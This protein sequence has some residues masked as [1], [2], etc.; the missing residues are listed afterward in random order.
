MKLIEINM[1][2]EI[3]VALNTES[4]ALFGGI[5]WLKVTD[6]GNTEF[7]DDTS[8]EIVFNVDW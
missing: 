1:R 4:A 3:I 2:K 7:Y 6:S 5:D 8:K